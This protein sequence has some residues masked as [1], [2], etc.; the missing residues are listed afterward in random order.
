MAGL[1]SAIPLRQALCPHKPDARYEAR[2][3]GDGA[4]PV[5]SSITQAKTNSTEECAVRTSDILRNNVKEKLARDEVVASMTVRLVPL[6]RDR[7]HRQDRGLR[8]LYI[9]LEHSTLVAG[10]LPARS[11]SPPRSRDCAVRCGCRPTRPTTSSRVLDG[12][13]LGVIAPHVRSAAEARAVVQAA[14]FPPLGERSNAGRPA[15]SAFSQRSRRQRPT[16]RS[17]TPP[18]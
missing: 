18:W 15:A 11:A 6:C 14:K 8:Q 13:A 3:D 16:R 17:T 2:H 1:V 9:D 7:A 10:K 12:G 5:I 4:V